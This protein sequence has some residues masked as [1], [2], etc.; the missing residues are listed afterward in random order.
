MVEVD[1]AILLFLPDDA[2]GIVHHAHN[3]RMDLG[4]LRE[5][6]GDSLSIEVLNFSKIYS[7][8]GTLVL[9]WASPIVLD[10]VRLAL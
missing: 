2:N 9:M 6:I 7:V 5:N 4:R 10:R 1:N 8:G 3:V